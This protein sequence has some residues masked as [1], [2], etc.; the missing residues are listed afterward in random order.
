[1]LVNVIIC[2]KWILI[3]LEKV[4]GTSG[5]SKLKKIKEHAESYARA[6][7]LHGFAYIGEMERH[8]SEK[9]ENISTA[10][11][12]FS[13]TVFNFCQIPW[14]YFFQKCQISL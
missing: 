2:S 8:W 13:L 14:S 1:M 9:Y 5:R 3:F 4:F 6:T 10:K 12:D 11:A 7:T